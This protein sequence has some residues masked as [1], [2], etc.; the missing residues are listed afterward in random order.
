MIDE[1][2]AKFLKQ[3]KL[4][5]ENQF[6]RKIDYLSFLLGIYT[7]SGDGEFVLGLI[8]AHSVMD[9]NLEET[10]EIVRKMFDDRYRTIILEIKDIAEKEGANIPIWLAEMYKKLFEGESNKINEEGSPVV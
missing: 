1:E 7:G 2:Y 5:V 6:K 9:D 4:L 8:R 3:L 10:F